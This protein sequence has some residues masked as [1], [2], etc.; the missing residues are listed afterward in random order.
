MSSIADRLSWPGGGG[1]NARRWHAVAR[2]VSLALFIL[3]LAPV[4]AW[5][6]EPER[7]S[8]P[9]DVRV[10]I[11]YQPVFRP[12]IV[13][14]AIAVEAEFQE[15][16]DSV[17]AIVLRDLDYSDRL[18]VMRVGEDVPLGGPV[19]Y[20]LWDQLG[21][22]WLLLGGIEGTPEAPVL[23]L[24]LHDVVYSL[25]QDVRAFELPPLGH[26]D[27]RHAIHLAADEVVDWATT[28]TGI[29]A[30]K[31]AYVAEG[32]GGSEIY[33]VDSDGFRAQRLSNDGSIALSPAWSPSGDRL[34]YM[35]YQNGDPAIYELSLNPGGST[36]LVDL[37]GLDLTPAY[38]P[39]GS[40]L[41]FGA[42][43][44]GRTEIFTYNLID[45]CCPE[46]MTYARYANSLSPTFSPDGSRI[47]F[48]SD[49]LG[50][51]HI[52][53]QP[54]P[55]GSAELLTPYIYD[56]S[57]HN[58]GPDWSPTADRITFHGWVAGVPQVF[59]VAPSGRG[60]RQL[61]QTGRNE[62]PSWAPDGR[63][64]VFASTRNGYTGL[65][66][67]DVESG[68]IRRLVR[69]LGTR[70][71]DWS[72]RIDSASHLTNEAAAGSNNIN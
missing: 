46:R 66:I 69:G 38:S 39:D 44:D 65:W 18:Q 22:V 26:A 70:L 19:N 15:L 33:V 12:G 9:T 3:A 50:Q 34:A 25:L 64:I 42:T 1:G 30:T 52:F 31:I 67:L 14:P 55:D 17:R 6:Q 20:G 23:R 13:M 2:V 53:V 27:L 8:I 72:G 58:A 5:A 32:P 45:G 47:A 62:D 36:L 16:A 7:D 71:P 51:L 48:N 61:T 56:R 68:R 24:S 29:A 4:F 43:V 57:V 59:T 41:A 40:R 11:L 37:P 35:S 21:A 10:G 63:H 60:L 54:L 28:S 49:R